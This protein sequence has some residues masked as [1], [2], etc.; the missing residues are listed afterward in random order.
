MALYRLTKNYASKRLGPWLAGAV[1]DMAPE[2]A[3]RVENEAA[4]TLRA[5]EAPPHDRMIRAATR[6]RTAE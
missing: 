2:D 1:V 3:Q 5:L 4:G 6:K